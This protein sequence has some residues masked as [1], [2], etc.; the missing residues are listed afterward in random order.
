MSQ[1]KGAR[2]NDA[3]GRSRARTARRSARE[4]A[5]Q[6]AYEWLVKG[7]AGVDDL[8]SIEAHLRED[9]A[10]GD[11][12]GEYFRTLFYGAL[13]SAD[14]LRTR[15]QP[16]TERPLHELSPVEHG[17]LLISSYELINH[18]DVPYKVVINEAVELAKS[19]GGT[20]GF[21]FVNGVLDKLALEARVTEVQAAR[22]R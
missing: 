8:V 2:A 10:F 12:D 3:Q 4:F 13:R 19:F 5:L 9:D 18:V 6:G 16:F 15:F 11:A 21:K 1:T 14:E 17:I 22:R 20:D 7:G